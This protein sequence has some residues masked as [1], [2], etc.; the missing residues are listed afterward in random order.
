MPAVSDARLDFRRRGAHPWR[1]GS[2]MG[3]AKGRGTSPVALLTAA[4]LAGLLTFLFLV[5]QNTTL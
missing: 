3:Y 2:S 4:L 1:A 5:L